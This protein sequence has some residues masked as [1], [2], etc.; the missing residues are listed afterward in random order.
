[1][2]TSVLDS[3]GGTMRATLGLEGYTPV[4]MAWKVIIGWVIRK[5]I[6]RILFHTLNTL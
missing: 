2:A 5:G 4:S 6:G 1:M 3:L